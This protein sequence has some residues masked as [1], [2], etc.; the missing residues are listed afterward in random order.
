[1]YDI[2]QRYDKMSLPLRASI[3]FILCNILLK[4][5]SFFTSPLFARIL[6]SSEYGK[7]TLYTTYE[8]IF[9]V[10]ATWEVGLSPT[11]RGLL[12][13]KD[14]KEVYKSS[15]IL[16][17]MIS[18]TIMITVVF[19]FHEKVSAFTEIPIWLLA[20]MALYSFFY[21]S[22]TSWMTE[23]KLLYNYKSVSLVTIAMS[24]IQTVS[25]L[26]AVSLIEATAEIKLLF[27]M[28][29]VIITSVF[30]CSFRFKPSVL[31]NNSSEVKNDLK[32][33][34]GFS[35]PL[36]MH[37]LSYLFLSHADSIMIGKM[38][39]NSEAGLYGVAYTISSIV[40]IIQNAVL[41]VLSPWIYHRMDRH[42]YIQI[43][44]K[45]R[46]I[47]L[48]VCVLYV[49][50]ILIAPDVI[51]FLYPEF[52]WQGIWCIPPIAMGMFFMFMYS[53]F[54]SIE[55]CL[56]QTKY[57]A[58]VS[59]VCASLNIALNYWGIKAFGYI[60]CAYTTLVCYIL[61]AVGHY[62]FMVKALKKCQNVKMFDGK[63][64]LFASMV[65]LCLMIGIVFIYN[66]RLLRYLVVGAIVVGCLFFMKKICAFITDF[67]Q[68]QNK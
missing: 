54:V 65:M 27:S 1:M 6:S 32:F 66:Q 31:L 46:L 49:L 68:R 37:S 56:D 2:K 25:A 52:Y 64:F 19:V 53:L 35:W 55:E 50:F 39:G 5:I 30:I 34:L 62:F 11:Q 45:T 14:A 12:K 60:A 22:Y 17:S 42:E 63:F 57:V 15:L 61:F 51:F 67:K 47:V 41:Q 4:G 24:V 26:L 58:L 9:V 7:L 28:I 29:P 16:F 59:I 10:L 18:S 13:F 48:F 21:S 20:C 23:N 44:E 8:Q 36:L 43:R 40:I 33:I 3:W 38:V